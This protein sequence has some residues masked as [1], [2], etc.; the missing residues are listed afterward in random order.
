L[1]AAA[2]AVKLI[3]KEDFV[4]K[5]ADRLL[6][7][8]APMLAMFPAL[9]T[10]A[11]IPFGDQLC[12]R[13]NGNGVFDF[14]DLAYPV[15]GMTR[16]F[17]C[18]GGH[19]VSLQIADLNVGILYL[20]AMAGTGVIGAAIAGWASDNKFSLLGGLRAASQMVSYEVAMGLSLAG[21]FI[22]YG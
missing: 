17:Q 7:A 1:H 14:G 18:A 20:F 13:D 11:V 4:P 16:S 15:A 5:H 6:H 9:V 22:I 2:D 8:L 10:F 12:F 19:A 21:L 3:F